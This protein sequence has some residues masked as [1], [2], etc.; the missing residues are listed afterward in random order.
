M[1]G[2]VVTARG[3]IRLRAE[4]ELQRMVTSTA[5]ATLSFAE[6]DRQDSTAQSRQAK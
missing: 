1:G 2:L 5:K 6:E 3:R 4:K